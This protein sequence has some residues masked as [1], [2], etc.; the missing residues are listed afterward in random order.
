MTVA[1]LAVAWLGLAFFQHA[2]DGFADA[3]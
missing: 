1:G 2:R 3:I